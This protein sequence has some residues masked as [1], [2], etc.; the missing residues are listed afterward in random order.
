MELKIKSFEE[1]TNRELYALLKLRVDVF[2]VEQHCAY[3]DLDGM[4]N[5]ALH[6]FFEEDGEL[7]AYM[8][9][10]PEGEHYG[11]AVMIGRVIAAR[12]GVGL[13]ARILAAGI[14]AARSLLG[15][16]RIRLEAQ[17]Y[18]QGFYEKAGFA[19]CSDEFDEDGIPHV[20]MV[21]DL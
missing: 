8:R 1:L 7:L 15:A 13:G 2:V 12:R 14:E 16:R 3:P 5:K 21:L 4:D 6:V 11:D 17:S 19:R 18:A 9:I 20:E 10:L